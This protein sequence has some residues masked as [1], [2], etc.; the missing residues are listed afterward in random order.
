LSG[1]KPDLAA[2]THFKGSMVYP[3]DGGTSAA[4]PV[5]AGVVAAIRTRFRAAQLSPFKLRSLLRKTAE[6]LGN[7]GFDYDYGWGAIN[8]SALIKALGKLPHPKPKGGAKGP[9]K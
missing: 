5:T 9:G 4:C 3:E 2:Y 1:R 6:D 7:L 8:P